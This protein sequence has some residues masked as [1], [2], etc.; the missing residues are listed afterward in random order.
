MT[1]I[2]VRVSVSFV[3]GSVVTQMLFCFL[4]IFIFINFYSPPAGQSRDLPVDYESCMAH[5][6]F[7]VQCR[8]ALE[9]PEISGS[10]SIMGEF[11]KGSTFNYL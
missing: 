3:P 6:M 4:F 5:S 9:D 1:S 11:G 7:E 2:D 8:S 10:D